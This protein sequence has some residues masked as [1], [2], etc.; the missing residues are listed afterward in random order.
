MNYAAMSCD[1]LLAEQ[2]ALVVAYEAAK[3][4]GLSLDLSRGKPAADQLDLAMSMLDMKVT[5][6]EKG[7]LL[8]SKLT[9]LP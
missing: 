2:K 1:A 6:T 3:A 5:R 9:R 8:R 7:F 4:K